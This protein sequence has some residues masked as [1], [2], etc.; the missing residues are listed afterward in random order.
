MHN[1]IKEHRARLGLTQKEVADR[2]KTTQQTI[3]RWET[4]K[5]AVPAA[6][7]KELA[8]L[9]DTSVD[10]L[11]ASERSQFRK[12]AFAV[13]N[14][15]VPFGTARFRLPFGIRE[16]PIDEPTSDQLHDNLVT[17]VEPKAYEGWFQFSTLDNKLVLINPD[18][19]RRISIISDDAEAMPSFYHPEVY[20][21]LNDGNDA[22][23]EA[24]SVIARQADQ[25]RKG[26]GEDGVLELIDQVSVRY[27]DGNV[28]KFCLDEDT[29]T[30]IYMFSNHA[31]FVVPKNAFLKLND[32]GGYVRDLV[33]LGGVAV[34]EVPLENYLRHILDD[35]DSEQAT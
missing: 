10:A 15:S 12:S 9:F 24:D 6:Q 27:A 14:H 21:A 35:D 19:V 4:F 1:T 13:V 22:S 11:L 25:I 17:Y 5:T 20:R 7:L 33:N 8:V 23:V 30:E 31:Q 32:E 3:A 26:L 2:L 34:L 29:A 18:F 28:D 16:Y